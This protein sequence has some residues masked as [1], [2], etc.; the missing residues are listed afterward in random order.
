M[1]IIATFPAETPAITVNGLHQWDYG[2]KLEIHSSDLPAIVEVHFSCPGMKDALVRVGSGVGGVVTV[3]IP[4][5]CLEQAS[6][7]T[8]WVYEVGEASGQT[9]KTLTLNIQARKRPQMTES[10]DPENTDKY[11]E[12][13]GAM[14]EA[15]DTLKTGGIKVQ[16]AGC[17]DTANTAGTAGHA[18][19]AS[20]ADA[21]Q[22]YVVGSLDDINTTVATYGT[23]GL[24]FKADVTIGGVKI[25]RYSKGLL[26]GQKSDASLMVVDP[27]GTIYTAYRSNGTWAAHKADSV[28]EAESL[29]IWPVNSLGGLNELLDTYGECVVAF[30]S[31][32]Q[33]ADVFIPAY[34]SGLLT[35][36]GSGF[37]LN[38]VTP[39]GHILTAFNNG[40]KW[41]IGR[42]IGDMLYPT[43]DIF[44]PLNTQAV[45]IEHPGIYVVTTGL[46]GNTHVISVP[47]LTKGANSGGIHDVNGKLTETVYD[48]ISYSNSYLHYNISA[49]LVGESA[50]MMCITSVVCIAKFN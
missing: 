20:T 43:A 26:S 17:A 46:Y 13:V 10:F 39:T 27:T 19:T 33:V 16:N 9:I 4:D 31:G 48:W 22:C 18:N 30:E 11:T 34:S 1:S 29:R 41:E 3:T 47:D 5:L 7:I 8:A 25:P 2:R 36:R 24:N 14:N 50:K 42:K 45:F 32:V 12:A 37:A 44:A 40:N 49:E 35:G 28:I 21:L 6:P 38:V 15:V 23:C